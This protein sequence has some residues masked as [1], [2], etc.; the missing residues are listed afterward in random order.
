MHEFINSTIKL[1]DQ[2]IFPLNA[3]TCSLLRIHK[4]INDEQLKCALT[5]ENSDLHYQAYSKEF[6]TSWENLDYI[7]F[8]QL[9]L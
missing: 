6:I 7:E 5:P 4:L 1:T 9:L 3:T 2:C 8:S